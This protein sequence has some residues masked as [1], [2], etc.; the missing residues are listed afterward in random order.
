MRKQI[1]FLLLAGVLFSAFSL[2]SAQR[3]F[4]DSFYPDSNVDDC[5]F[6]VATSVSYRSLPTNCSTNSCVAFNNGDLYGES[7]S[8][9]ENHIFTNVA[10]ITYP[11]AHRYRGVADRIGV[12]PNTQVD[13]GFFAYN[14]A[15]HSITPLSA[16]LFV[17][18]SNLDNGDWGRLGSGG[19]YGGISFNYLTGASTRYG[20]YISLGNLGTYGPNSMGNQPAGKTIYSFRT[21]Q[22]IQIVSRTITPEFGANDSLRIRYDLTIKNVSA[23]NLPNIHIVDNLPNGEVYDVTQTFSAGQSKTLTYYANMGSSYPNSITASAVSVSDPNRH[24]EEASFASNNMFD[25]NPETKTIII[26]RT[27]SGAPSGWTGRQPDFTAYSAGDYFFVELIPYTVYSDSS[28]LNI[29]PV[30][31]VSKTV[32]DND[33][34]NVKSNNARPDQDITYTITV[35]NTGGHAHNVAVTDDYD[36]NL[37]SI[38]DT[39]GGSDNGNTIIW[40]IPLLQN[41]ET[42]T[43]TI[44]AKVKSP[45]AHGVYQVPNTVIVDSDETTP[46][47]DSTQTTITAEVKMGILKTVSDS[48]EAPSHADNIQG[49]QPLDTE[50]QATYRIKISNTGDADA[51]NTSIHD[52]VSP[53]IRNGRILDIQNNGVLTTHTDS[54]GKLVGEIVWNIG[55]LPQTESREVLFTVQFNAGIADNIQIPNKADV[56]TNEVPPVSDST[57]TTIHAPVIEITK[58]DGVES[59]KPS[60]NINWTINVRNTGTGN[61]YNVEVYD[62][63]PSKMTVSDISDDGAWDNNTRR[64]VWSTTQPLYI[65]N[66][67]YQPDSRSIWGSNKTLTFKAKLDPI[68]PI[69]TT[70]LNN[71]AIT[72]TSFYPP[73]QAEHNLPVEAF[74]INDIEKYVLNETAVTKGR[75]NSGQNVDS[76][77][78][79]AY[80]DTVFGN[81][82]D[83]HAIAGD[84]LKYTIAYR[85]TGN[86][87]SPDTFITD[88][89]PKYITDLNGNR[90]QVILQNDISDIFD[91]VAIT[92]TESG[93]DIV[94]RI[95]ELPVSNDWQFKSFKIKINSDSS[96]TLSTDD[97]KRLLTNKSEI[98]SEN[99][100]V[101]PDTDNAIIRIDQPNAFIK[102]IS[103]KLEYQSDEE[104]IY[105]IHIQNNGSANGSGIVTDIL[106]DGLRL[107]ST[108]YPSDKTSIDGRNINFSLELNSG[109]SLDIKVTAKF[110]VPVTDLKV[111]NNKVSYN[112]KDE[113]SNDR[114][115]VNDYLD[116]K[117]HAPILE[118]IK[119]QLLP[120]PVSPAQAITY[121]I[122]YKN[123]GTGYSP[124]TVLTDKLPDH[125]QF[126]EFIPTDNQ[127][128]GVYD[129]TTKTVTWSIGKLE[130]NSEGT[131]SFKVV[132]TIPTPSGSE[133]KNVA[134][135]TS[136]VTDEVKS[137]VVTATTSSCCMGGFIWEDFNSNGIYD[138]DEKGIANVRVS[139]SW[140]KTEFL[141]ENNVDVYTSENGRYEYTGLPYNTI[142]TIRIYK[143]DGFDNITT[144]YEY[145]I[146][147]LPSNVDGSIV[148]YVKDGVH[149]FTPTSC[150]NFFDAGIYRDVIIAQ[151]GTSALIPIA[152]SLGLIITGSL[153]VKL[154]IKSRKKKQ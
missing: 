71:I 2:F 118:L 82:K 149:Y 140:T 134:I 87:N 114:P 65:L 57:I 45:L 37:L 147:L 138:D 143:P 154:I 35:S 43:F 26:N 24:K 27:D 54:N 94:W 135:I 84:I 115:I 50:R 5:N 123:V 132:I 120:E 131:V 144:P 3:V 90:F 111:F 31:S 150:S 80:A 128:V 102:K 44:K 74:P 127:I 136:P 113:N 122:K 137:E 21:I 56:R 75:P 79:G 100:L 70:N 19:S 142:L 20:R 58:D 23:Y 9:P 25:S 78:Y 46:I 32:S 16:Y 67:S 49:G 77:Q 29:P 17:S 86:A 36:Q 47:S 59:A 103:D 95:G 99:E 93:Y 72:E 62:I 130:S 66:G 30:I 63:V 41:G 98:A 96:T 101:Q 129:D 97:A 6:A 145:K 81:E 51:H 105:T 15:G 151:T 109:Q 40:N 52:D 33:E 112:Y 48:D 11:D 10:D 7:G 61:A 38:T 39:N 8:Y 110:E 108:D 106:P 117:V 133:I 68:F 12:P 22:P 92:E 139:I 121:T 116:V 53:I 141:P 85:N 42:R 126:I 83:V 146:V 13:V 125:V 28:T 64:V 1:L 107:I 14:Y 60:D 124:N 55:D 76:D 119:E 89:L 91:N 152:V 73:H 153:L 4:A 104:V 69:G 148:D 88:H 34:T 18:R